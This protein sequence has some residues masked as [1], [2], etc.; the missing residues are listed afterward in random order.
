M[1]GGEVS[2]GGGLECTALFS[3][4]H[5]GEVECLRV[6]RVFLVGEKGMTG[7]ISSRDEK[8][9]GRWVW[10]SGVSNFVTRE[11]EETCSVWPQRFTGWEKQEMDFTDSEIRRNLLTTGAPQ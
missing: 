3:P 10:P 4:V 8:P 5:R 9:R 2:L 11:K 7:S 1:S 6:G